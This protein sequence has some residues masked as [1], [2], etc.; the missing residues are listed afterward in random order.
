VIHFSFGHADDDLSVGTHLALAK[1]R[2]E[3]FNSALL[4]GIGLEASWYFEEDFFLKGSLTYFFGAK[5]FGKYS[6]YDKG[7]VSGSSP[8]QTL[9]YKEDDKMLIGSDWKLGIAIG[10]R[11]NI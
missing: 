9:T 10:Y 8:H 7:T 3:G 5:D 11:F 2:P 4:F 6:F 1:I